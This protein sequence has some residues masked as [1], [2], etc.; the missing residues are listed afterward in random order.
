MISIG[1]TE[2]DFRIIISAHLFYS[3]FCAGGSFFYGWLNGKKDVINMF[4]DDELVTIEQ[5]KKKYVD[6]E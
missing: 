5:L 2:Y 4:I 6:S 3:R 1:R